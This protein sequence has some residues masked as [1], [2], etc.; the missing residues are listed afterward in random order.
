MFIGI[1]IGGTNIR[2]ASS[3]SVIDPVVIDRIDFANGPDY[4]HNMQLIEQAIRKLAPVVDGIGI[5][6][7]GRLNEE[8]TTITHS[9][10]VK[11]WIDQPLVETLSQTF[12]CPV[13][14]NGD[15]YCAAL[16]EAIFGKRHDDFFC[17]VYGTGLGAARVTYQG[18]IPTIER[19]SDD[20]HATYLHPWQQ[21]CGGKWVQERLGKPL[22]ELSEDEWAVIMD[23][24][25]IHL[26]KF[27]NELQPPRLVFGGGVA[28][29]QWIRLQS[30]FDRFRTEHLDLASFEISLAHYKEDAGLYGAFALLQTNV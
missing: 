28:T 21:D 26:A 27:I 19:F 24:F 10:S 7:P 2:V 5:G 14:M 25:Y 16:S 13:R 18:G 23:Q 20:E 3:E 4:Q 8:L 1:D 9:R 29:K 30:V 11:Q 6:M 15:Q 12:Q 22:A 17:L